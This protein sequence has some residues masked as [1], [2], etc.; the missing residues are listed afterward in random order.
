ML[1][2]LRAKPRAFHLGTA[3]DVLRGAHS[4]HTGPFTLSRA[5]ARGPTGAKLL[6]NW[7]SYAA[8]FPSHHHAGR[9]PR[10]PLTLYAVA[11]T[12]ASAAS[13]QAANIR[14]VAI[15]RG[16][17]QMGWE[18]E[19]GDTKSEASDDTVTLDKDSCNVL[20]E[21]KKRQSA[22]ALKAGTAYTRTPKVFTDELGVPYHPARLTVIFECAAF[23]A[24]L[25]P[26]AEAV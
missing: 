5:S 2:G 4:I 26:A 1:I 3:K 8:R 7:Q 24:G 14:V 25:P 18:T 22:E 12:S 23:D 13:N 19:E 10:I 6:V 9:H 17:V 16:R 20:R 21:W 11:R 15:S